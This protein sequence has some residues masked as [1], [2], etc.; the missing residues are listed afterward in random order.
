[1]LP[2]CAN[3]EDPPPPH[4]DHVQEVFNWIPLAACIQSKIFIVHGGLFQNDGVT[5]EDIENI[6]RNMEPPE[7]GLMTDILWSD[8]QPQMG[9][10][11][12][13]RGVGKSFGPDIT[14]AFLD[15]NDLD[16]LVRSHEVRQEGYSVEHDGKC[17]TIFSAPNYCDQV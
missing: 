2:I 8:P 11:A 17:I 4:F 10:S 14:K 13:K 3:F 5:L 6:K 7:E 12:S 1:M 16:L 9:R 15:N